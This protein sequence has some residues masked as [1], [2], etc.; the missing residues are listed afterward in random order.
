MQNHRI[1]I[2]AILQQFIFFWVLLEANYFPP[3]LKRKMGM[4]GG[5]RGIRGANFNYMDRGPA[6]SKK[7]N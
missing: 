4:C 7:R 3:F 1:K 6:A 2:Q 5:M